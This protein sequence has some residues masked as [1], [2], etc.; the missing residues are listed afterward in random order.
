MSIFHGKY[1]DTSRIRFGP[2][3]R[4]SGQRCTNA[5]APK[6]TRTRFANTGA[7]PARERSSRRIS[8]A[9]FTRTSY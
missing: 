3:A 1:R 2:C 4:R 9:C 8:S 5:G 7:L 6:E